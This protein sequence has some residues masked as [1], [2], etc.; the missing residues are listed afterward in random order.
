MKNFFLSVIVII[1]VT[2]GMILNS[3]ESKTYEDISGVNNYPT[4]TKNI[5]PIIAS[6][7]VSC[8]ANGA[9]DPNLENYTEV[10]EAITSGD[11]IC[12]IDDQS[13]GAVMP[14]SGRLPQTTID[15]I[16]L[17]VLQGYPN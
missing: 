16:K 2:L 13:C 14:Q 12:R 5:G 17:W 3:C 6:N 10:K 7:C 11:L 4:Y 8:H 15:L 9:Q 1:L